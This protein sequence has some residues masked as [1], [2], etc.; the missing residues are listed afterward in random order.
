MHNSQCDGIECEIGLYE[1]MLEL[2]IQENSKEGGFSKCKD[3]RT[4]IGGILTLLITIKTHIE[5]NGLCRG[6]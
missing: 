1:N 5:Y 4:H 6:E 2:G 3:M